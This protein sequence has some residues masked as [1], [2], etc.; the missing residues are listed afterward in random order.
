[1]ALIHVRFAPNSGHRNC[2]RAVRL[3]SDSGS[4]A[5]F[6]AIRR[7]C[8]DVSRK[9][10]SRDPR[11]RR[12]FAW[13]LRLW[14]RRGVR[15]QGCNRAQPAATARFAATGCRPSL[16]SIK[17]IERSISFAMFAAIRRASSLVSS[18]AA[19][20]RRA[21]EWQP[22]ESSNF[23]QGID[24]GSVQ[25]CHRLRARLDRLGVDEIDSTKKI[26]LAYIDPIVA[27]DGVGHRD[28]E[29]GVGDC[30]LQ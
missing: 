25:G 1:L 5:M 19:D 28:V 21:V 6:A 22:K 29:K 2:A 11:E 14:V 16:I 27:E 24:V 30:H 4:L 13:T 9:Q 7:A 26:H 12:D 20:R 18:L 17:E 8:R 15:G 10:Q 3:A 23:V